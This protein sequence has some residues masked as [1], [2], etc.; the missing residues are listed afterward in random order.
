ML[1][2]LV[3]TEHRR[4]MARA[5]FAARAVTRESLRPRLRWIGLR[6]RGLRLL[7]RAGLW[8]PPS[9]LW[10]DGHLVGVQRLK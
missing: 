4:R 5:E 2:H 6:P 8:T 9:M 1:R 7:K 10:R 3:Q